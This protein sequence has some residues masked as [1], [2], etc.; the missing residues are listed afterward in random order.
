MYSST[1]PISKRQFHNMNS[2]VFNNL[3][4][5]PHFVTDTNNATKYSW[6]FYVQSDMACLEHVVRKGKVMGKQQY[7]TFSHNDK[8][9]TVDGNTDITLTCLINDMAEHMTKMK[10]NYYRCHELINNVNSILGSF[11]CV[12]GFEHGW[13]ID[14]PNTYLKIFVNVLMNSTDKTIK[15]IFRPVDGEKQVTLVNAEQL[16]AF[17]EKFMID[18]NDSL[19]VTS[20]PSPKLQTVIVAR[21]PAPY[22]A[23]KVDKVAL[24]AL[25][26]KHKNIFTNISPERRL[27]F[28]SCKP[29][30]SKQQR[31]LETDLEELMK[32]AE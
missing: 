28:Q 20:P 9:V 18:N 7:T 25:V 10:N 22:K 26:K 31:F 11:H 17:I 32:D 21:D 30:K 16:M 29:V 13:V 3:R 2:T 6:N 23:A 4:T 8:C 27:A 5:F 15:L 12:A 24:D 1:S 19:L 14:T